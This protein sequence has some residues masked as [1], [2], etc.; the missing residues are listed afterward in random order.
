MY[1]YLQNGLLINRDNYAGIIEK[2]GEIVATSNNGLCYV[3]K[4]KEDH[5]MKVSLAVMSMFGFRYVQTVDLKEKYQDIRSRC[6]DNQT[7]FDK[8]M[9]NFEDMSNLPLEFVINDELGFVVQI[10]SA[11]EDNLS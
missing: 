3:L 2:Y 8:D 7:W 10:N 9:N 6:D 5:H 4:K 1:S 11:K